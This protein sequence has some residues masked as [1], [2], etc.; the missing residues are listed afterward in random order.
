VYG[1]QYWKLGNFAPCSIAVGEP[2]M[3]D[4]FPPGGKGYKAASQEIIRR[5]RVLFDWLAEVH[6]QN[7]PTG[8]L[9]PTGAP[10][11]SPVEDPVA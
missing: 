4:G 11:D 1:T 2:F 6:A 3:L 10:A 9:P 7:R 5:I 8:L